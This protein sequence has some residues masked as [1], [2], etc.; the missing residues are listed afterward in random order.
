MKGILRYI[1]VSL[2]LTTSSGFAYASDG[3]DLLDKCKAAMKLVEGEGEISDNFKSGV[4][5]GVIRGFRDMND[6]YKAGLTDKHALFCPPQKVITGQLMRIAIKYL[7]EN[8]SKLHERGDYLL[9]E[10]Y[11]EAFPCDRS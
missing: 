4:C 5:F 10:A 1:F 6:I 2:L 11:A 8:P 7:E 3:N 9:L